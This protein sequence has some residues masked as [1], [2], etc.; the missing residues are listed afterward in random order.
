MAKLVAET[1][2]EIKFTAL[3]VA[4]S[5]K[6]NEMWQAVKDLSDATGVPVGPYVPQSYKDE[7]IGS[8]SGAK[9]IDIALV[10]QL[11]GC[12]ADDSEFWY[13]SSSNC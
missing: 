1:D 3:A 5:A 8:W 12:T 6:L 10:K 13:S 7:F 9:E 11:T 4:H 2:L